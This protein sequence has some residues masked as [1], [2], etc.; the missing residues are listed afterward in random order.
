M[1][2]FVFEKIDNAVEAPGLVVRIS[3]SPACYLR[4]THVFPQ[5]VYVIRVST[6]QA[7][8]EARRPVK[9]SYPEVENLIQHGAEWGRLSM[10]D[11]FANSPAPDTELAASLDSAWNIVGPLVTAME[12][13]ANLDRTNFQ[14]LIT[15]RAES[16]NCTTTTVRRLLI[17]YYY[18]GRSKLALLPLIGGQTPKSDP[19]TQ[20]EAQDSKRRGPSSI[21]AKKKFGKNGFVVG[22]DDINDMVS[23][24]RFE[25]RKGPT[26][27]TDAHESY[28]AGAFAKRHPQIYAE[29]LAKDR[30][31]PVSYRQYCYYVRKYAELESELAENLRNKS[32]AP[33]S[34]SLH[35]SGP[36]VYEADATGGRLY[37]VSSG[38]RPVILRAPTIYLVI[39][40]WSRYIVSAYISVSPPS[41]E[42]LRQ[43]M[44]IALTSREARF[45]NL[46]VNIDDRRWPV[47]RIP[48]LLVT[49]RG[50][51]FM[52]VSFA[53]AVANDM[54]IDLLHLPP[55]TP[56]G[57][58]I[59][60]RFI[61]VL[62]QRMAKSGLK[63]TFSD[64]ISDHKTEQAAN[65]AQ[66]A[67]INT[68]QEAYREL[69][70]IV[71]DH[72]NR[73]HRTLKKYN[74]LAHAGVPPTPSAAYQW[75][76]K[77]I[78]GKSN[79]YPDEYYRRILLSFDRASLSSGTLRYRGMAYEPY[80][81]AA[82]SLVRKVGNGRKQFDIRLDKHAPFELLVPTVRGE[83]A[84][85]QIISGSGVDIK[86]TTLDE[87][88]AFSESTA[89]LNAEAEADSRITRL[90]KKSMPMK[91]PL[92]AGK[93]AE[94]QQVGKQET[95]KA[96]DAETTQM[97]NRLWSPSST[98]S[99]PQPQASEHRTRTWEAND[100]DR[101]RRDSE[102]IKKF[103]GL[104]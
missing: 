102:L 38:P 85:F 26:H 50:S 68:L 34:G 2:N 31:L 66:A 103:M 8:R 96:S 22:E 61:R 84:L 74:E 16:S 94:I 23:A 37:L 42:E 54:K 17:R 35:A 3:A 97:K 87:I 52:S 5:A 90:E 62:K 79:T 95:N 44:L 58:A 40:R 65:K 56:D 39:D 36:G 47:G 75:G 32:S 55:G 78:T 41:Y 49:D 7:A 69:V 14:Q 1:T 27:Y 13:E 88:D 80:N 10:P 43:A 71:V 63:G 76:L 48:F 33:E 25:L 18:F 60:E 101:N 45:T 70:D 100:D 93:R 20:A 86:G 98:K 57:K 82:K 9:M 24:L 46:G 67:A 83:P 29:H 91:R 28:L 77:N 51:E 4:I 53:Q 81:D 99:E 72:N 30:E 64:R 59:V 12:R 92:L 15:A 19:L 73:P 21:L 11:V 104:E 89:L 6:P